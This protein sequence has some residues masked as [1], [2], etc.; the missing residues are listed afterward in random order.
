MVIAVAD[1]TQRTGVPEKEEKHKVDR[2]RSLN[3]KA[4]VTRS[5]LA[6][7][8]ATIIMA[9]PAQTMPSTRPP[10]LLGVPEKFENCTKVFKI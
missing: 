4:T 9:K 2:K 7:Y 3:N 5:L 10:K 8:E 1:Y 6:T